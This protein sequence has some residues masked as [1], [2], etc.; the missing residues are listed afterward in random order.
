VRR[1]R[2]DI[3]TVVEVSSGCLGD[4]PSLLA[5]D[6]DC[7]RVLIGSGCGP[8]RPL[9]ERVTAAFIEHGNATE[10]VSGLSG[11]LEQ[12]LE[13][14]TRATRTGATLLAG[15]GG[16][17][18]IDTVKLAA[19]RADLDFISVPTT[20]SH[21]GIS[22]P[23]ASLTGAGHGRHSYAAT[24]PSGIVID[25]AVIG[26]APART[27]RAGTGDLLSNLM[28]I[29]DWE[30]A[31][32][33]GRAAFDSFSSMI[34]EKAARSILEI[35]DLGAA[36]SHEILAKGLLLSGLAMAAA[37][38]SRPCSGAEH[39]IS[40]SLDRLLGERAAMHGE[41]VAVGS[42]FTA[43]AHDSPHLEM[44]TGVFERLGLPR[45]PADLGISA[46]EFEEAVRLAPDT[47]PERF[48]ILTELVASGGDRIPKLVARTFEGAKA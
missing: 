44:L 38:T 7:S 3:P 29:L 27:L 4:L 48:T 12:T 14:A 37:G 8:S 24:M 36:G 9:A 11:T 10:Q 26:S 30:L 6:F 39:L 45:T 34:A 41:Q 25:L 15:V 21:D 32:D 33:R 40:H 47:R 16:G 35:D 42:L 22:S 1:R 2:I 13:L 17:R 20:I 18:V 19:A 43:A 46:A 31:A 28:A 5:D 23:V